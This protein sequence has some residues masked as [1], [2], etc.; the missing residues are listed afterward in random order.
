MKELWIIRHA[1]SSWADLN[2][3]DHDRPLNQRGKRDAPF[4][5]DFMGTQFESPELFIYSS[6]KRAKQTAK[7][8]RKT[9]QLSK[10]IFKQEPKFYHAPAN[11]ILHIIQ[12]TNEDVNRIA[13]FGHNP[14]FTY[15]VNKLTDANHYNLATCG[16]AVVRSDVEFWANFGDSLCELIDLFEPKMFSV[17]AE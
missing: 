9:M 3:S 7:I 10:N 6:A 12:G 17:N 13:I 8:F 15:L 2:I 1:K 5:A 4:M 14:G 11:E 16:I